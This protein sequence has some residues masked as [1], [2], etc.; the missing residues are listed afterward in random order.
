MVW[1]VAI[2]AS[3]AEGAVQKPYKFEFGWILSDHQVVSELLQRG[4]LGDCMTMV[5]CFIK[6]GCSISLPH[7]YPDTDKF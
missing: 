4:Y 6:Y 2:V 5:L 7:S 3:R 1:L